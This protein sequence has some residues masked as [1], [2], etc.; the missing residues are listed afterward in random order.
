MILVQLTD[1]HIGYGGTAPEDNNTRRCEAAIA[2][3]LRLD[4]APDLVVV[5]GDLTEHGD[6]ASYRRVSELLGA[7]PMPVLLMAGNHDCRAAMHEVFPALPMPD[8][9]FQQVV[10]L[11]PRRLILLDT[12]DEARAGGAFDAVRADW[13]AARLAERP[14]APTL[15]ALHHPPVAVGIDWMDPAPDA[16]WIAR[17]AAVIAGAPQVV[18]LT[19]GHLHQPVIARFAKRPLIVASSVAPQ[20]A[21]DFRATLLSEPDDRALFVDGP[22]AFVVHRWTDDGLTSH[23]EQVA[24]SPTLARLDHETAPLIDRLREEPAGD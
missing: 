2:H 10:E 12:L 15:I 24:A 11:G 23:F 21:L 9:Y 18:A 19:A 5:S 14:E 6:V 4:P 16:P 22:P 13:L 17:L 3:L 1:L 20:I 7:L 8:G